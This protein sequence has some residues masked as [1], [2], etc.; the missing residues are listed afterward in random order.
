MS[1]PL[2]RQI[3]E[4][5]EQRLAEH[6]ATAKGMDWP[7]EA[8]LRTRFGVMLA[9]MEKEPAPSVDLLD[10]GCGVGLLCDYLKQQG[11][12]SRYRY[13]GID[14]SAKMV[15]AAKR[16]HPASKFEAR[17]ILEHPLP[18]Q[19]VDY[20][21]MNGLLTERAG[22]EQQAMERFAQA[23]VESAYAACRRGIAF[24]AMSIH[25]D[26]TREDLFHWPLDS[27]AAFLREKCT[28]HVVIRAD[29]GLYEYTA[30]AF[31]EPRR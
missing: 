31:R 29:Y 18:P 3:M 10:L 24:N 6:G 27:V 8:D 14:L 4:H 12:A 2:Y 9:L 5:Y 30:Y 7:N 26:W 22:L 17:D 1:T 15:E 11:I 21:V 13:Q 23:M 16:L 20:V 25:V 19:S 28:R